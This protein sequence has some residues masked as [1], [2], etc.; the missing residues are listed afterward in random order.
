MSSYH[1]PAIAFKNDAD[2]LQGCHFLLQHIEMP[3]R[4]G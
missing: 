4:L 2:V 3:S 1:A